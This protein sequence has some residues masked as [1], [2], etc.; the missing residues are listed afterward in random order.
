MVDEEV[1]DCFGYLIGDCFT[2]DVEVGG[3]ETA[4]ELSFEGF[5]FGEFGWLGSRL[6][7]Y[8]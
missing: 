7:A 8:N 2:N 3:Y 4:D 1:H 6:G 5:S